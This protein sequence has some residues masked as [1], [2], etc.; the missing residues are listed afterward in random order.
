MTLRSLS[1]SDLRRELAR[2]EASSGRLLERHKR[3]VARLAAIEAELAGL[4]VDGLP[5]RRGRPPGRVG[6][7]GPGR[8]KGSRNKGGLTLLAAI[9]KG[10]RAGTTISPAEAAVAAKRA[11]YRSSSP[12]L[13]MMCANVMGKSSEFR[14]A[15]RG[16]YVLK[17]GAKSAAPKTAPRARKARRVR[18]AKRKA[19]GRKTSRAPSRRPSAATRP[20]AAGMAATTAAASAAA[21]G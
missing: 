4:G 2:R 8:P 16:A 15:G 18:K 3:L 17:S 9:I 20:K 19:S 14:H 7:R 1:V 21:P 11:G 10:V 12:H 6:R 5:R 13:A